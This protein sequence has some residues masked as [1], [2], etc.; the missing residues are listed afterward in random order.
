MYAVPPGGGPPSTG[1]PPLASVPRGAPPPGF[2]AP[3]QG[4]QQPPTPAQPGQVMQQNGMP[5]GVEKP[6]PTAGVPEFLR[7]NILQNLDRVKDEFHMMNKKIGAMQL[8]LERLE[9]ERAH[10]EQNYVKYHELAGRINQDLQ[11]QAEVYKRF[12]M[13]FTQMLSV[14]P[15]EM[16]A[17]FQ[18]SFEQAKLINPAEIEDAIQRRFASMGGAPRSL[19]PPSPGRMGRL[20]SS[21]GVPASDEKR[22]KSSQDEDDLASKQ[23]E[24]EVLDSEEMEKERMKDDRRAASPP[25]SPQ[26]AADKMG[27]G[28]PRP[29][30]MPGM[31][32]N[33]PPQGMPR[34]M[35]PAGYAGGYP[36]GGPPPTSPHYPQQP[37]QA[38]P[39]GASLKPVPPNI[40]MSPFDPPNNW[41]HEFDG[42]YSWTRTQNGLLATKFPPDGLQGLGIPKGAE[43]IAQLDHGEVVCAVAIGNNS[44]YMFTG[45]KGC[46]KMW[47]VYK[48]KPLLEL[49][50]LADNYIRSCKLMNDDRTLVV[51]GETN[52]LYLWDIGQTPRLLGVLES[53]A[54]ACYALAVGPITNPYTRNQVF[55]CCS[56][57]DV[58]Q[59]DVYNQKCIRTVHGHQDG[60]SC[61]DMTQDGAY[62]F[63]GGLD[64]VVRTWDVRNLTP[65]SDWTFSFGSQIFSLGVCPTEPFLAVGLENSAVEML[66]YQQPN[67]NNSLRLHNSCVLSLKFSHRGNWFITTGKDNYL[68]IWRTL[69]GI[70][71]YR[72][73]D[74]TSILSCDVAKNDQLIITGSGEKRANVYKVI[75]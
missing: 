11:A 15:P 24:M 31:P 36:G 69:H 39:P 49:P 16:H 59:W 60:A 45:G 6:G 71:I 22:R 73:R 10:N 47:D 20:G 19:G 57:G 74:T 37:M 44:Q 5:P 21:P 55:S 70:N 38:P 41:A 62:V 75:F 64:N 25:R 54:P 18:Q 67:I 46:V 2:Q 14:L 68:N 50:C 13:I 52:S 28:G 65:K 26:S 58:M 30:A 17:Q 35:P 8:D 12:N 72:G 7:F 1:T 63:T 53:K 42:P 43:K 4:A 34:P 27:A 61:I 29:D 32:Q 66:N 3:P 23:S 56:D 48:P 33:V 40:P 51:G 9:Q